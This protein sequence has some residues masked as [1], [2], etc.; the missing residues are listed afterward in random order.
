MA[1]SP[2]LG[3]QPPEHC[4]SV[5]D[6]H[7]GVNVAHVLLYRKYC[8]FWIASRTHKQRFVRWQ[9][10]AVGQKDGWLRGMIQAVIAHIADYSDPRRP[11]LRSLRQQQIGPFDF[12]HGT[13]NA[14]ANR[15]RAG[16]EFLHKGLVDQGQ[17]SRAPYFRIVE[18]SPCQ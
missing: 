10:E 18:D 8:R 9:K 17:M 14:L 3:V 7:I 13:A 1:L 2:P 12:E 11:I 15:V 6:H 16:K 4:V 5:A